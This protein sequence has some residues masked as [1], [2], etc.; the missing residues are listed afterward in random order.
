MSKKR[1]VHN[2]LTLI[3]DRKSRDRTKND[4]K[5]RQTKSRTYNIITAIEQVKSGMKK[6][7]ETNNMIIISNNS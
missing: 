6:E 4:F 5:D 7:Q 1:T 3:V 2:Q